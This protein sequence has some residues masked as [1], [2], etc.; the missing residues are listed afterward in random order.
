[1]IQHHRRRAPS[2]RPCA[3]HH[4]IFFFS[5]A[6]HLAVSRLLSLLRIVLRGIAGGNHGIKW[7]RY[8]RWGLFQRFIC[9]NMRLLYKLTVL[10]TLYQHMS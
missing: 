7:L 6:R 5:G 9:P 8:R 2:G 10:T 1:M 3:S 4:A